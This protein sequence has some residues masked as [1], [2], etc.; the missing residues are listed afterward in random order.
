[1]TVMPLSRLAG[2]SDWEKEK[3]V[4]SSSGHYHS[5]AL[6]NP[7][8]PVFKRPK[9]SSPMHWQIFSRMFSSFSV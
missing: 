7:T 9:P 5:Y 6:G 1:M 3:R 4:G 8:A 2:S